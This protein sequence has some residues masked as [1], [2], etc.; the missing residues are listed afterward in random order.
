M[1]YEVSINNKVQSKNIINIRTFLHRK[2]FFSSFVFTYFNIFTNHSLYSIWTFDYDK[3]SI[4]F[5][6]YSLSKTYKYLTRPRKVV[7]DKKKFTFIYDPTQRRHVHE[8]T[9]FTCALQCF[10][11]D[12]YQTYAY[13]AYQSTNSILYKYPSMVDPCWKGL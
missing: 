2:S 9:R 11:R 5:Y 1:H 7:L 12:N 10:H 8:K 6:L 4:Q 3:I 13:M